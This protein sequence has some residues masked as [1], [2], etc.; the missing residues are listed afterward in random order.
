[1]IAKIESRAVAACA[2]LVVLASGLTSCGGTTPEPPVGAS[3]VAG[4]SKVD[5]AFDSLDD[6][7]VTSEAMRGKPTLIVFVETGDRWSP[8]QVNFFVVMAKYDGD[9]VN[10]VVVALE[11]RSNRE[12]VEAYRGSLGV[13]FPVALAD[14]QSLSGAGPF[15]KWIGLPTIVLLDRSGRLR[16]RVDGHVVKADEIRTQ[17]R[18]LDAP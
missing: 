6:R 10:Y 1:M 13:T 3:V 18:A 14:P 5:F 4:P 9:K 7:P 12:L 16:W 11:P 8:A 17:L 15:G 2:S